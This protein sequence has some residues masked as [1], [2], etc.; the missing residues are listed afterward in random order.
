MS[1][2]I[3]IKDAE[4]KDHYHLG[5]DNF[6][7]NALERSEVRRILEVWDAGIGSGLKDLD[8]AI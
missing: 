6:W 8:N 7:T 3:G 5:L 2:I 4:E 1:I